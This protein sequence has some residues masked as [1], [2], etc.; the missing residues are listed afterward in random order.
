M[1]AIL[2]SASIM[3]YSIFQ[4]VIITEDEYLLSRNYDLYNCEQQLGL[5]SNWE[6]ERPV[7]PTEKVQ[8]DKDSSERIIAQRNV[9]FKESL[10]GS[11]TWLIV[12]IIVLIFHFPILRRKE[13]K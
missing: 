2:I 12:A 1:I 11:G 13:E 6:L 8:C 5:R 4:K 9:D 3:L 10:I 7:T